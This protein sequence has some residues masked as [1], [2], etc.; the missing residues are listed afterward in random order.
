MEM[1][2]RASLFSL[3]GLLVAA[4]PTVL[5]IAFALSPSERRLALMRPLSLAAIF[6]TVCNLLVGFA[7]GLRALATM[8]TADTAGIQ[9]G[10]TVLAEA[11]APSILAFA[12]LTV[13][14]LCVAMGMRKHA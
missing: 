2:A 1:L 7:N 10:A 14:W 12:C 9:F 13:A 11:L 5:G 4:A 3:F 6:A 8:D